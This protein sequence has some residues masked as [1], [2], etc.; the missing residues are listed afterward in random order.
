MSQIAT[1]QKI[2]PTT[3]HTSGGRAD[4]D[5]VA[6]HWQGKAYAWETPRGMY[7]L[8]QQVAITPPAEMWMNITPA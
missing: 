3:K 5:I 8:G 1:V 4:I 6:L 2:T 7:T